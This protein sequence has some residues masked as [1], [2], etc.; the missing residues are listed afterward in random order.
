MSWVARKIGG[1]DNEDQKQVEQQ[2]FLN[3]QTVR[4][5][6]EQKKVQDEELKKFWEAYGDEYFTG[7]NSER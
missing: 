5:I 3:K 2:Y 1:L 7:G 4:L 6:E